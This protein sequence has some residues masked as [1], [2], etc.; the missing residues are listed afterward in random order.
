MTNPRHFG[1]ITC[2]CVDRKRSWLIAGTSTG[3][4]NL[5]DRRFGLLLKS[6]HVGIASGG[7][8]VRVH[9]CVVHPTKGRGRWVIVAVEASRLSKDK[10]TTNLLEVW[11]IEK[12]VLVESFVMN[13]SAQPATS[14]GPDEVQTI[15][16][17]DAETSPAAALAALVKSRQTAGD[18]YPKGRQSLQRDEFL[19]APAPDVRAI[20]VG[21]DFGGFSH[22][23]E[24]NMP[25]DPRSSTRQS[26]R[27]F[28]ISG[29]EDRK[30]RL[31]DLTKLE[32]TFIISGLES[33]NESDKPSYRCA[34]VG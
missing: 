13:T 7:R 4:L 33:E 6:W 10:T 23:P 32:R 8:S 5:W 20:V 21:T 25:N 15:V 12:A 3:V 17:S 24:M 31:W 30:I 26:G 28:I 16:G 19:A 22:R 34:E 27:G 29:S 14:E 2:L 9:Q 11:D 1:P 18:P